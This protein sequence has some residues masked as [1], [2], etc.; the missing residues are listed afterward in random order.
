MDNEDVS[1]VLAILGILVSY[2]Y[3]QTGLLL[4]LVEDKIAI[5]L[6]L[7]GSAFFLWFCRRKS[8]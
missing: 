2:Q 1:T 5:T 3:Y 6:V 7:V 8:Q 4:T